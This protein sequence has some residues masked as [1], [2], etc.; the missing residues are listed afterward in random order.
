MHGAIDGLFVQNYP[1]PDGVIQGVTLSGFQGGNPLSPEHART[2]SLGADIALPSLPNFRASVNYFNVNYTGQVTSVLSDLSILQSPAAAAKYADFIVQGPQ[3]ASLI[4]SFVAAGYPVL[5]VLPANPTLFVYGQN[6]NSGKTLA[7]GI[8][9]QA[10]Y[11]FGHFQVSTSGTYF[12][13]YATAV[14]RTAPLTD[15]LNTLFNPPRF[16]SRSSFGYRNSRNSAVIFWNFI[17][18]YDNNRVTPTQ[19]VNSYSTFDL[20]LSHQFD[21]DLTANSGLTLALDVS[22]LFDADPPFVDIPQS[23]NGGG[24]F[25]PTLASPIGRLI[26][27]SAS[28]KF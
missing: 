28:V 2:F 25:D 26:S 8:D 4:Q 22:N 20:H 15:A 11:Q 16:R 5:G 21:G 18:A 17:N 14:T 24:G 7:Q 1:T 27:I 6:Q 3:A 9:F 12:T 23:P 13:K 10:A 19:K